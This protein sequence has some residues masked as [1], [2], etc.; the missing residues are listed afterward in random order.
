MTA[1]NT[2]A[3]LKAI[4]AWR[5]ENITR[6]DEIAMRQETRDALA[7]E[8]FPDQPA[9]R[10]AVDS[11]MGIPIVIDDGIPVGK[12]E[13]RV[14]LRPGMTRE[15]LARLAEAGYALEPPTFDTTKFEWSEITGQD[16]RFNFGS[17]V[18]PIRV[19]PYR[20]AITE[21]TFSAL[22]AAFRLTGV[23]I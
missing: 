17:D 22:N 14:K 9:R 19:D 7:F 15:D 23:N 6:P 20:R 21:S 16:H 4:A 12:V 18:V 13:L 10:D 11:I 2:I 1:E 5:R 8:N 3:A